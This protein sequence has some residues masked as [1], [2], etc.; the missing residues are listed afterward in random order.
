MSAH[1]SSA[2]GKH[3]RALHRQQAPQGSGTCPALEPSAVAE[4]LASLRPDYRQVLVETF[5]LGSSVAG[6]AASLGIPASIVKLRT[7]YALKALKL[8]LQEQGLAP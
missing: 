3:R 1:A 4:A 7:F 2:G 5:F 8:A 6:A